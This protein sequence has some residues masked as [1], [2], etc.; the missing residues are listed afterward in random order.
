MSH[1]ASC[2]ALPSS[3]ISATKLSKMAV[4]ASGESSSPSTQTCKIN[5]LGSYSRGNSPIANTDKRDVL[6]H[7]PSPTM[8]SLRRNAPPCSV[9]FVTRGDG[10][11]WRMVDGGGHCRDEVVGKE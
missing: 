6:P 9:R 5:P 11:R 2:T 1:K 7:A 4:W 10:R 8:T 3:R